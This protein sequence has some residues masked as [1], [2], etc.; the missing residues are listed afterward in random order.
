MDE[1]SI[2]PFYLQ[3]RRGIFALFVIYLFRKPAYNLHIKRK[4]GI[5]I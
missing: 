4:E 2:A 1:K 3:I 5:D